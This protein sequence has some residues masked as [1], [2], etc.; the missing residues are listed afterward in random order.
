MKPNFKIESIDSPKHRKFVAGQPCIISGYQGECGIAHHL[1]R[2]ESI[3]GTSKKSCD[4]WCVPLHSTI[5]D[6]LHKNGNEVAFFANHGLDYEAV[7][8]IAR[9]L[10]N[11]SPDGRIRE[12]CSE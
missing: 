11:R 7:K 6:A 4:R 12:I 1:L 9:D 10:S 5:H 3:K 8:Q 2:A